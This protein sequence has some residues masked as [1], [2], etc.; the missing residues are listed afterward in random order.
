MY[1]HRGVARGAGIASKPSYRRRPSSPPAIGEV[2]QRQRS[3]TSN[4]NDGD[5]NDDSS[6]QNVKGSFNLRGSFTTGYSQNHPLPGATSLPLH[7]IPQTRVFAQHPNSATREINVLDVDL[8][9]EADE[10]ERLPESYYN[11]EDDDDE[12]RSW[13]RLKDYD[14]SSCNHF[15]S[16][17]DY[18]ALPY[19]VTASYDDYSGVMMSSP[20]AKPRRW[21]SL[22]TLLA[23]VS[24]AIAGLY[25]A[26]ESLSFNSWE[27]R[28]YG[29]R[30]VMDDIGAD[31]DLF[32]SSSSSSGY[33]FLPGYRFG[34]GLG[35]LK[36]GQERERR[37]QLANDYYGANLGTMA[38]DTRWPSR[39]GGYA[40]STGIGSDLSSGVSGTE[41]AVTTGR[42]RRFPS[43]GNIDASYQMN[44][45]A[46]DPYV[47]L[48]P[49]Q[50]NPLYAKLLPEKLVKKKAI[51]SSA[52]LTS[53]AP[54]PND[55][56]ERSS[57]SSSVVV[58]NPMFHGAMMDVAV[59]PYNP[60]REMP[61]V[62][63]IPLS[64]GSGI[65]SVFGKC[66][67][68]VQ[69][70]EVG[71]E[72][73]LREFDEMHDGA[74]DANIVEDGRNKRSL[75]Q[76][77]SKE[78]AAMKIVDSNGNSN[79]KEMQ[80][81]IGHASAINLD[82][83]IFDPPLKSKFADTSTYVNVDCTTSKGVDRGI[84]HNLATSDLI[85]VVYSP[86]IRD[87]ARL[88]QPPIEAYGRAVTLVRNPVERAV[89]TYDYL[90][91]AQH[92]PRSMMVRGMT[93]E[94]FAKS[95]EFDAKT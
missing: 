41:G 89:A 56:Y 68:L 22:V 43:R 34:G 62:W 31:A 19:P 92:D 16:N 87:V 70:S 1:G 8:V 38:E 25:M 20:F 90:R 53:Y 12:S 21:H 40:V 76:L 39:A 72:L 47:G 88:F 95:G 84:A 74:Y 77:V 86:D 3:S 64:G 10:L 48:E 75:M 49:P 30:A 58:I 11:T 35:G 55:K 60:I 36:G 54:P 15:G 46:P 63:D 59:L 73:L 28:G 23:A 82:F 29:V 66:L 79:E 33:F 37:I 65:E 4:D 57:I 5:N 17:D 93:L 83:T 52:P 44:H 24:L 81:Q 67:R 32:L 78:E 42:G 45:H 2:E 13:K 26:V 85:D 80:Q 27:K 71:N 51:L 91:T 6:F 9:I 69:C 18:V 94:D 7:K 14:P 61:V 50:F